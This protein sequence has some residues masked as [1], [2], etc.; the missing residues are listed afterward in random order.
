VAPAADHPQTHRVG[1]TWR[2]AR[3]VLLS[4]QGMH[5]AK[6]RRVRLHTDQQ[7]LAEQ[8]WLNRIK[9][10]C[11]ALRYFALD[12]TDHASHKEQG[13]MIRRHIIWRNKDAAVRLLRRRLPGPA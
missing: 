6:I 7:L 2:R 9:A 3:T 12:G 1:V 4:A 10:Q 13:S 11:T 5:V 8:P